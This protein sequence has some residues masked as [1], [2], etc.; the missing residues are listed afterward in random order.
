MDEGVV[1]IEVFAKIE[2]IKSASKGTQM[3]V[4]LSMKLGIEE[5]TALG[6]MAN[7]KLVRFRV[8]RISEEELAEIQGTS[9]NEGE[10]EEGQ[11]ALFPEDGDDPEGDEA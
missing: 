1:G 8:T 2:D 5:W 4:A 6:C 10:A 3:K 11:G 7:D 9:D